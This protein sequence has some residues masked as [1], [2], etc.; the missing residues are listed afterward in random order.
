MAPLAPEFFLEKISMALGIFIHIPMIDQIKKL[1]GYD[2][3]DFR[4]GMNKVTKEGAELLNFPMKTKGKVEPLE[5]VK[6]DQTTKKIEEPKKLETTPI[7][8]QTLTNAMMN[9]HNATKNEKNGTI[10]I[11]NEL[12]PLEPNDYRYVKIK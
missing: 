10:V 6:I 7:T 12:Q 5:S 3:G 4:R 11:S 9:V 1:V 8:E 2:P